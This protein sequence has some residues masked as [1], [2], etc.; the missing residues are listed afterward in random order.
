MDLV[1]QLKDLLVSGAKVGDTNQKCY[2]PIFRAELG[3]ADTWKVGTLMM[4]NYYVVFDMTPIFY[5]DQHIRVGIAPINP[6]ILIGEVKYDPASSVYQPSKE[7]YDLS[8]IIPPYTNQYPQS[9]TKTPGQ[10][11]SGGD[12][13][14]NSFGDKLKTFMKD[15]LMGVIIGGSVFIFIL[16][17]LITCC[18]KKKK[19]PYLFRTYSDLDEVKLDEEDSNKHMINA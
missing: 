14:N 1:L 19:D 2:I 13:T 5:D 7:I 6:S 10:V 11:P 17:I 16:V 15:N 8:K 12:N 3:Q 4:Q 9:G 18:C